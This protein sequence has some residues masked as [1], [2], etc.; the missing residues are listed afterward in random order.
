MIHLVRGRGEA[1][2]SIAL[3]QLL[4][5]AWLPVDESGGELEH[6]DAGRLTGNAGLR[7]W[8]VCGGFTFSFNETRGHYFSTK[9]LRKFFYSSCLN[10]SKKK[11][12]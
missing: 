8:T 2:S 9:I 11:L 4:N 1:S 6:D 3:L 10:K 7:C 12:Q 5:V